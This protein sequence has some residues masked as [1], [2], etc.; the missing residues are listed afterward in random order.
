MT[1]RKMFTS[2]AVWIGAFTLLLCGGCLWLL[3]VPTITSAR[4]AHL[5]GVAG[6]NERF[7][8]VA[9]SVAKELY[10]KTGVVCRDLNEVVSTAFFPFT[11][12]IP[13]CAG[14][15]QLTVVQQH[16]QV[17]WVG[18]WYHNSQSIFRQ[19]TITT[20]ELPPAERTRRLLEAVVSGPKW[21]KAEIE[22]VRLQVLEPQI[23]KRWLR[24]CDTPLIVKPLPPLPS[25]D[26][27]EYREWLKSILGVRNLVDGWE[28]EIHLE[29][30][31]GRWRAS[32]AGMDGIWK[33][34]DDIVILGSSVAKRDG[35]M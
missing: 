25:E 16:G 11:V 5:M 32:S 22:R 14:S 1:M 20:D 13:P 27:F 15:V 31:N 35:D 2:R 3:I 19:C 12:S 9:C 30:I 21:W 29:L 28:R 34:P 10:N 17:Q 7:L 33:T 6:T 8:R 24:Y 23:E 4:R 26:V 18:E